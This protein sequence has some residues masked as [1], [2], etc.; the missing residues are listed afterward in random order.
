MRLKIFIFIFFFLID[1]YMNCDC[2]GLNSILCMLIYMTTHEKKTKLSSGLK[3][4]S[5]LGLS[6]SSS[7]FQVGIDFLK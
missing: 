7:I 1:F 5:S 3:S 6:L 2:Y 4:S